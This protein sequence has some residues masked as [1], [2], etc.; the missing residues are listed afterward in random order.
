MRSFNGFSG[1]PL[2]M[3][4]VA[5][6]VAVPPPSRAGS[7]GVLVPAYFYPGT[8]G[9]GGP[10]ET[11]GWAQL[12]AAAS[13]I[14]VT[15]IFNPN[16]GPLPGSPDPNYVT[17]MTNLENAGGKVVAYVPTFYTATP[18]ATVEGYITTYIGQY[19]KLI[20][21]FFVDQMTNDNNASDLAYYHTLYTFIKGL[22]PSYQVIGNPGTNTV[23]DYLTP[24]TQGADTLVT[25]ENEAQFYAGTPPA[26]WTSGYPRNDFANIIHTQSSVQGMMADIALAASRNVGSVYVTDQVLPNPYA[27]LPSYWDQEVAAIKSVPEPGSL[28]LLASG[29]LLITLAAARQR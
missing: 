28:T 27:Q 15:A 26:P 19:G 20:N 12:A 16:S 18:L 5:G 24:N 6:V 17:A 1:Y 29:A 7:M 10:G 11:D 8:G 22:S 9:S 3:L 2:L 14:P 13:Q 23:P 25:Y 21:G 4:A